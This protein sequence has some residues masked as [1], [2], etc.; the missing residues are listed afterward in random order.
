MEVE[1]DL[2]EP[3]ER[4][5]RRRKSNREPPEP[6]A[7]SIRDTCRVTGLGK[8]S[9]YELISQGRLKSVAVGRRRLVLA[10][11]IRALLRP[12]AQ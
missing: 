3:P 8:T 7:Y 5:E 1:D 10:E 9:I 4:A 12:A 11:S 6:S 2:Q